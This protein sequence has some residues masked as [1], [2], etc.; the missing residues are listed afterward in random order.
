[1]KNLLTY[2][3]TFHSTKGSSY[4]KK[5]KKKYFNLENEGSN[6]FLFICFIIFKQRYDRIGSQRTSEQ[7]FKIIFFFGVTTI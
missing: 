3:E 6:V 2:L 1:M 4:C 5:K 7:F